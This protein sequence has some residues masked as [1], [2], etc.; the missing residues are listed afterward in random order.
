MPRALAVLFIALLS[1]P[2]LAQP[3]YETDRDIAYWDE[4]PDD[5]AAERCRL[6]VYRPTEAAK[7]GKPFVTVVW[8]HPGGLEGG[9]RYIPDQLRGK[10]LA[11]VPVDYRL[12][13][14]AKNPDY[15]EDAAAAVAWT[16]EHI[17]D[18]G[19][20]PDKVIVAGFSAGAYLSLMLGLDKS[21]LAAHDI[22]ADDLLAIGAISGHA[23]V[24]L[25]IRAERGIPP[26]KVVVD[27]FA[28][29]FHVRDDA[30]P[31][32]LVTG[33]RELELFG[34]WEENALLARMLRLEGHKKTELYELEGFSHG[35]IERPAHELFLT[36]IRK[37]SAE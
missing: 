14:K 32:L 23:V 17:A 6:D 7:D 19:G 31:I 3:G 26:T 25:R 21:W 15:L 1:I 30:P 29:L 2:A 8:F 24:H 27:E 5:Y 16:I 18:Y 22:D 12:S 9:S 33:G 4:A 36:F 13:P 37:V 35:T 34:R 28:P 10:G 20:D 11:V